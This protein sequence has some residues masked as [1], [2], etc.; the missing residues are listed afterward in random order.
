LN[1]L[2]FKKG[3]PDM[4]KYFVVFAAAVCFLLVS[5]QNDFASQFMNDTVT[6]GVPSC[7]ST[8][9]HP[10]SVLHFDPTHAANCL[11]CHVK[12]DGSDIVLTATCVPCHPI[13]NPGSCNI[14]Q[15]KT[16][17]HAPLTTGCMVCHGDATLV[18]TAC[19]TSGGCPA[20][21]VLGEADPRLATLRQFRDTV[22]AKSAFGKRI[23]NIYYNNADAI[24]AS[25]DKS[26]IL[27]AFSSKA[28]KAF[29]PVVEIFM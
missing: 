17:V 6:A 29:I 15:L 9:C 26:P 21:K 18:L 19:T 8:S 27:K 28:I 24:N 14:V 7:D 4:K 13:G 23:I 16:T 5:A 2:I 22:L 10:S 12:K 25:L 20:T 11:S 3:N 1:I